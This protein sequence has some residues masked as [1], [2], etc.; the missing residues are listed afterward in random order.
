[1]FPPNVRPNAQDLCGNTHAATSSL[2]NTNINTHHSPFH[3]PS[4]Q[5]QQQPIHSFS[6]S[7]S[8]FSHHHQQPTPS[9]P[10]HHHSLMI[11]NNN[12][13]NNNKAY[14]APQTHQGVFDSFSPFSNFHMSSGSSPEN[15]SSSS[16]GRDNQGFHQPLYHQHHQPQGND[17][18]SYD[19][20]GHSFISHTPFQWHS[21]NPVCPSDTSHHHH[22]VVHQFHEAQCT[23][24]HLENLEFSISKSTTTTSNPPQDLEQSLSS[25]TKKTSTNNTNTITGMKRRSSNFHSIFTPSPPQFQSVCKSSHHHLVPFQNS[26]GVNSASFQLSSSPFTTM[27]SQHTLSRMTPSNSTNSTANTTNTLVSPMMTTNTSNNTIPTLPPTTTSFLPGTRTSF[28]TST[29]TT[30]ATSRRSLP[31]NFS[32]LMSKENR[33]STPMIPILT[34]LNTTADKSPV[35]CKPNVMSDGGATAASNH[36]LDSDDEREQAPPSAPKKKKPTKKIGTRRASSCS[37]VYKNLFEE[38]RAFDLPV[39]C[40][41]DDDDEIDEDF[42]EVSNNTDNSGNLDSSL[43]SHYSIGSMFLET[44]S[45]CTPRDQSNSGGMRSGNSKNQLFGNS[46]NSNKSFVLPSTIRPFQSNAIPFVTPIHASNNN[47]LLASTPAS[48]SMKR[49]TTSSAPVLECELTGSDDEFM[50]SLMKP[51][52]PRISLSMKRHH[53]QLQ[54]QNIFNDFT[55]GC[56]DEELENNEDDV[57][58]PPSLI[59]NENRTNTAG[60]SALFSSSKYDSPIDQDETMNE[61]VNL[62][63]SPVSQESK[64]RK[65]LRSPSFHKYKS[66]DEMDNDDS[67]PKF[68]EFERFES[69]LVNPKA[70]LKTK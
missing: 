40:H 51:P 43:H 10:S 70:K 4:P 68:E 46:C 17:Y 12:N 67:P 63:D 44:P 21:N 59:Y 29:T 23:T 18:Y 69:F 19:H 32:N 3:H 16:Q 52:P 65:A 20:Y 57:L 2:T 42:R 61:A 7:T 28:G 30:S 38:E 24:P 27:N 1:M 50:S 41:D 60:G 66:R 36:M 48:S 14:G 25:T 31:S 37:S 22:H 11:P 64:K 26:S 45:P 35:K 33:G 56:D 54:H 53:S 15:S 8:S 13:N 55:L 6:S 47:R 39:N 62:F 5:Q 58:N 49:T 34:P 9:T